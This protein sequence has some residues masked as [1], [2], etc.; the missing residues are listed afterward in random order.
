[1]GLEIYSLS[2]LYKLRIIYKLD[3]KLDYNEDYK[4]VLKEDN[5]EFIITNEDDSKEIEIKNNLNEIYNESK[6]IQYEIDIINKEITKR[7]SV[8]RMKIEN[9]INKKIGETSN[10]KEYISNI[11]TIPKSVE[12][13]KEYK[14]LYDERYEY[15]KDINNWDDINLYNLNYDIITKKYKKIKH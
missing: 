11:K 14:I 8:K 9:K 4:E 13:Y 2:E 6:N 15:L 7:E 12:G 3:Y 10:L 1:M 5:K